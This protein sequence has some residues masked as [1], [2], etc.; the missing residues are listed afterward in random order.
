MRKPNVIFLSVIALAAMLPHAPHWVLSEKKPA[1]NAVAAV[2]QGTSTQILEQTV[3]DSTT[4]LVASRSSIPPPASTEENKPDLKE[5]AHPWDVLPIEEPMAD[6][7]PLAELEEAYMTEAFDP[8]WATPLEESFH[9]VFD[10]VRLQ[11]SA[12]EQAECRTTLCRFAITHKN[13]AAQDAFVQA[14]LQSR[15]LPI[16]QVTIAQHSQKTADGS[17]AAVYFLARNELAQVH[18]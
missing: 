11:D 2:K 3:I 1:T 16:N 8:D 18:N 14:F 5:E 13:S 15:L 9:T 6:S 12:V 7:E 10:A 4:P 17:I